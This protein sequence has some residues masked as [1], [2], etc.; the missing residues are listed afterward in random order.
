MPSRNMVVSNTLDIPHFLYF[1]FYF[2]LFSQTNGCMYREQ[3]PREHVLVAI[4]HCVL[5]ELIRSFFFI[6]PFRSFSSFVNFGVSTLDVR[7]TLCY[8]Y[9][10]CMRSVGVCIS[11]SRAHYTIFIFLSREISMSE[12]G[13]SFVSFQ[14]NR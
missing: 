8:V 14:S 7:C 10:Y 3:G 2:A 6:F 11:L 1:F 4:F 5:S 12:F 9:C 13:L